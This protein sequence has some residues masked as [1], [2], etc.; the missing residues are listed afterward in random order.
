MDFTGDGIN[1]ILSGCYWSQDENKPGG[2]PQA[3]YLMILAGTEEGNFEEASPLTDPDNNPLLNVKLTKEQEENYD[4]NNIEM[5]NICTAQH[6]VDY[7][8]DGD[9]DLVTGCFGKSFFVFINSSDDPSIPPAFD[10]P[11]QQLSIESPDQHSNPHL[12]DWD[13]DGDLDLLTGGHTG[14]VYL[15]INQGT[16]QEPEWS[17]FKR[18]ISGSTRYY[19]STEN[20]QKIQPGQ[21]SRVWVTDY[22]RDGRPD[23]VVGDNVTIQNK[24]AGLSQAEFDRRKAGHEKKMRPL[25][26]KMGEIQLKYVERLE[27]LTR[28]KETEKVDQLIEKMQKEMQ[29]FSREF[30]QLYQEQSEFVAESR[31]GHV[32]VY[33]QQ[34]GSGSASKEQTV[35]TNGSKAEADKDQEPD[36]P[37]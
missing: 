16:Q 9:L 24:V 5:G 17:D 23:L 13:D 35:S 26:T 6:A 19:Q 36:R 22:N 25:Q 11:A 34:E 27:E 1:D 12:Y 32:W 15:S 28:K 37:L 18:L 7:D 31:T 3:G 21:A 29:P 2:N 14:S 33:L 20:G 10:S 30:S 8:G 4:R